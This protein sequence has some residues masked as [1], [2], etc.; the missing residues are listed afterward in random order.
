[1]VGKVGAQGWMSVR[2][3][4]TAIGAAESLSDLLRRCVAWTGD[5]DTVATIALAAGSCAADLPADL[6]P[7]LL[8]G[9]ESGPFGRPYLGG[10]DARLMSH[11]VR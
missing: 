1:V 10:L 6:P 9:L 11:V 5:V 8:A 3:A 2:A 7:A 4:V